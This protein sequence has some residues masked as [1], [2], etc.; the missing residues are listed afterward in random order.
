MGV[1]AA[2]NADVTAAMVVLAERDPAMADRDQLGRLV[3]LAR[4][5]RGFL[6]GYDVACARRSRELNAVGQSESAGA[7]LMQHGCGSGRDAHATTVREGV[8]SELPEFESALSAGEVSA[9]H[10]DV[11]GKHLRGLSDDERAELHGRSGELL[12]H[13]LAGPAESFDK[14]VKAIVTEIRD[15]HRPDSDVEELERQRRDSNVSTWV[16]RS[17]GMRKTLI[18]LDPIRHEHWWRSFDAH[19]ARLKAEPSSSQLTW[20]QLKVDAFLATATGSAS[21]ARAPQ[22]TVLIDLHTLEHGRHDST[23]AELTDGTP[24]PVATIR[25][26]LCGADVL[27]VVLGGHGEALD[28]GRTRRLATRAQRE[29]LRAMYT[30]C[31]EPGCAVSFDQCDVHHLV[32]WQLAGETDLANLAPICPAGHHRLHEQGWSVEVHHHAG[33]VTWTRPDGTT[34]YAGPIPGRR[35]PPRSRHPARPVAQ[36]K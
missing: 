3:E 2:G 17:S 1:R 27:P 32:P 12:G 7:M 26:L 36:P 4:R 6:D 8:C 11:L 19:L 22:V 15:Q 24:I 33:T 23:I 14:Q 30:T 10:L 20:Q 13:A 9:H 31:V 28:V 29:A 25:Q 5:V 34:S 21:A 18:E 16:D 35:T